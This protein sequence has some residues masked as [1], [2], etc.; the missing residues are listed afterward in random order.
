MPDIIQFRRGVASQLP[1]LLEAEPGWTTDTN[2][3]FIGDGSTNYRIIKSGDVLTLK[4][5]RGIEA[6]IPTLAS[7]ELGWTIDTHKLFVGTGSVNYVIGGGD[8]YTTDTLD[9]FA[10]T[11][12]AQLASI[13]IDA[14]GSGLLVFSTGADL[15]DVTIDGFTFNVTG[16]VAALSGSHTGTN[17]GDDTVPTTVN[18]ALISTVWGTP[19]IESSNKIEISGSC[20]NLNGVSFAGIVD[21]MIKVTDGAAD[22]EP[23]STATITAAAVPVGTVMAGSGTATVQI[24]TNSSGLFK[25]AVNETA[26]GFRYLWVSSGLHVIYWVRSNVGVLELQFT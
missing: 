21:I 13:I 10:D 4:C 24:R 23:S 19:G 16:N 14:T 22:A 1:V 26:V 15:D 7:G 25:I 18:L 12:S 9:Q 11:T 6:D 2:V 17:T 5:R 8:A 20:R 3:L